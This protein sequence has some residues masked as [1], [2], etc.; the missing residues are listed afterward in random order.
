MG[1]N[2]SALPEEKYRLAHDKM[3]VGLDWKYPISKLINDLDL[4]TLYMYTCIITVFPVTKP[5]LTVAARNF[6]FFDVDSLTE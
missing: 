3:Q 1:F 4:Y 2:R 6:K 5:F